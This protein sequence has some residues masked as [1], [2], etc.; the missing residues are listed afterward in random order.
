[1]VCRTF[2]VLE[3]FSGKRN[4]KHIHTVTYFFK[5]FI[6]FFIWY[7]ILMSQGSFISELVTITRKTKGSMNN[8][9]RRESLAISMMVLIS[10]T[11]RMAQASSDA[12][13]YYFTA[14]PQR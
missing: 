6:Y 5:Y 8:C 13:S 7:G 11:A 12:I 2:R 14:A 4:F 9:N 10:T 3:F 1:M